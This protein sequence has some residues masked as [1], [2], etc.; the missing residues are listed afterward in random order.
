MFR[1]PRIAA[2]SLIVSF[3][4]ACS[5]VNLGQDFDMRTFEA[6]IE[7]GITTQE[8]VRAWLGAPVGV[9]A[10]VETDGERFEDW[11]YYYAS[12]K[13]PNMSGAKVKILQVKFDKQ[14]IV[15]SYNWS[16]TSKE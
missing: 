15:R 6:K 10:C 7:R 13:L 1:I 14:G 16:T 5:T 12:G 9:G 3:L 2:V 11:V 4:G 8:Q